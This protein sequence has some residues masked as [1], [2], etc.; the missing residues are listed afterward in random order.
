[1]QAMK[2]RDSERGRI[3]P[4]LGQEVISSE[5]LYTCHLWLFESSAVFAK[6]VAASYE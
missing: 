1:M 3:F 5:N 6:T 4:N 2:R